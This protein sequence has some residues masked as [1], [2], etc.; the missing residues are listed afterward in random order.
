CQRGVVAELVGEVW[1]LLDDEVPAKARAVRLPHPAVVLVAYVGDQTEAVLA[2]EWLQAF[3]D[4]DR[5]GEPG[6]GRRGVHPVTAVEDVARG[7]VGE[8]VEKVPDAVAVR[9][10]D[11]VAVGQVR[12]PHLV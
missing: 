10:W 5:P 9:E 2:R 6:H 3:L 7:R 1:L 12:K 8:P 11:A 4:R